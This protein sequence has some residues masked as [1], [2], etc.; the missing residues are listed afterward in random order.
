MLKNEAKSVGIAYEKKIGECKQLKEI[1]SQLKRQIREFIKEKNSR[2][3]TLAANE[4]DAQIE[5]LV[6]QRESS[7]LIDN[8]LGKIRWMK[9]QEPTHRIKIGKSEPTRRMKIG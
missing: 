1:N 7:N 2:V 5:Q 9:T 4:G 6:S 3:V 8:K